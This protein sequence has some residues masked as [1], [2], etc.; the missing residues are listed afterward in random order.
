MINSLILSFKIRNCYRVNSIIYCLKNTPIIKK[1]LPYSLYTNK[2][3][4]VFA[5]IISAI[6]ELLSIFVGKALYIYIFY[7]IFV[8][9]FSNQAN[10]YINIFV[11]LT[12]IGG[13]LNT[14]MFNPSI[15]KYYA[16]VLMKFDAKKYTIS[17][18]LYYLVKCLLGLLPFTIIVGGLFKVPLFV[19][20]LIPF[21]IVN[22][23]NIF[24]AVSLALYKKNKKMR[25][26]NKFNLLIIFIVIILLFIAYG[27]PSLKIYIINSTIFYIM[28]GISLLLGLISFNYI[29]KNNLYKKMCKYILKT[30]EIIPN[31]DKANLKLYNKQ[32]NK[33]DVNT[34]KTGYE[35][36]N[37]IFVSR[38]KKLLFSA[39]KKI[40]ICLIIFFVLT[41]IITF[42]FPD[43]NKEINN[44]LKNS[45][46]YYLF[47]MY[48]INRGQKICQTMFM[49]CDRSMLT[50]RFY[51]EKESLLLLFKERLKTLITLNIIP[52]III[53]VGST[54]LI[55]LTGGAKLSIYIITFLTIISMSIFFS[56]H[57][58]VLYYLLQPYDI[59][60]DVKN[61]AFMTICGI[62]YMVCYAA[63]QVQIPTL[64]FGICMCLFTIIY[65]L[66]SLLFAYKYAPTRFK[67][68]L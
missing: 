59:N 25:N 38:H 47:V 10:A 55:Y 20:I 35:Y 36:F 18:Y 14:Y 29:L 37:Y 50:Y 48:F 15:D 9:L 60:L 7:V 4:K 2:G 12:I 26:E 27:L 13:L 64:I 65:T 52:G 61:P 22:I 68:R 67:L 24:N 66:L 21:Y 41:F 57:Y 56:I 62:T 39:T 53:A 6:I 43:E 23:K 34:N 45:I 42:M 8:P 3:F 30:D 11:Y 16:I 28:F 54:L 63:S 58:L 33:E 32:I 1:I 44:F 19:D 49:N 17:N 40:S 51:R 31:N 46:P 5:N